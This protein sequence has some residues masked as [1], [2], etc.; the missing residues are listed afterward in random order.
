MPSVNLDHCDYIEV[1]YGPNELTITF[2]SPEAYDYA[3]N[4]W[5]LEEELI[6]VAFAEGCGDWA[7]GD[8]CY[9]EVIDLE[10]NDG[11][12]I[13]VASG[14][15]C[16]P[17]ERISRGET[18][19][20]WW[21]PREGGEG[22]PVS[23]TQTLPEVVDTTTKTTPTK[24]PAASHY[25]SQSGASF[26]WNPKPTATDHNS[27]SSSGTHLSSPT[28]TSSPDSTDFGNQAPCKAPVDSK[29]GLPSACLG[30]FFDLDLDNE[31][32]WVSPKQDDV[33]FVKYMAPG[34][35]VDGSDDGEDASAKRMAYKRA[36]NPLKAL[37]KAAGFVVKP[38][39]PIVKVLKKVTTISKSFNKQLSWNL[40]DPNNPSANKLKD[41]STKQ[42]DS[43]WGDAVL[44]KA[45]GDQKFDDKKALN[46]YMNI[47]CVG[48]GASGS[49]RVAGKAAWTPFGGVQ[50]GE[51]EVNTD[52]KFALKIGIDAQMNLKKEFK[53]KLLNIGL[54]GLEYGVVRIGPSISLGTRVKLE[55]AAKGKLLAGA[56]VGLQNA[57]AFIDFVNPSKST[58]RGFG[59]A[60]Q[61]IF[62]AEGELMLAATLGL[63]VGVN[64]G[65]KILSWTFDISL[66]DEPSITGVAQVAASVGLNSQNQ[67]TSGFTTIEG[68]TGILAKIDFENRIW[69]DVFGFTEIPIHKMDK[70]L[71]RRCIS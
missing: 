18:E 36:F 8:R 42:V 3:R 12:L 46:G 57:H 30:D 35:E 33:D 24:G 28:S 7:K 44:L 16:D 69:V 58:Q 62:E 13:I 43:P 31:L 68:C 32:G 39:K 53:N 50:Y 65:I 10:F 29:F 23:S 5:N 66:I 11:D 2:S 47:F 21:V 61:P 6:L 59:P 19:W 60:F 51:V 56:E 40:P 63:P 71:Y 22:Y 1:T 25:N 64:C 34:T 45:F 26:S 37:K 15:S 9:F 48:C 54:P 38:L 4:T 52:G 67:F 49:A 41:P 70:E 17:N 20:G 27:H 14:S 55:A